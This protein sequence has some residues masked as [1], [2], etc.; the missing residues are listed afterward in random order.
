MD[1]SIKHFVLTPSQAAEKELIL[2]R[3]RVNPRGPWVNGKKTK[4]VTP[5]RKIAG[6]KKKT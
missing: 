3:I 2:D 4:L 1:H 6:T 5:K